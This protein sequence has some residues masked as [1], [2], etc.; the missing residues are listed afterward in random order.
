MIHYSGTRFEL[1][2]WTLAA[3]SVASGRRGPRE[4]E[5]RRPVGRVASSPATGRRLAVSGASLYSEQRAQ[6]LRKL[7]AAWVYSSQQRDRVV[8]VLALG[9]HS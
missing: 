3:V 8:V 5:V 7:D 1:D 9:V 2:V 4:R 6:R